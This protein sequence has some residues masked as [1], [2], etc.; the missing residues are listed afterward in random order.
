MFSNPDN[1]KGKA[2]DFGTK[3][4]NIGANTIG[5]SGTDRGT[6]SGIGEN[7][8][9]IDKIKE[10]ANQSGT[11]DTNRGTNSGTSGGTDELF[12]QIISLIQKNNRISIASMTE[13]L[14]I[15]KRTLYRILKTLKEKGILERKGTTRSGYWIVHS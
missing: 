15:S 6:S 13:Q 2:L 7:V 9:D 8:G 1:I 12:V 14:K 3:K 11:D 5:T 10:N 4:E